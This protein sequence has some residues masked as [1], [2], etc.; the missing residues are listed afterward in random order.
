MDETDINIF[1]VWDNFPGG[2][3]DA[4]AP[5]GTATNLRWMPTAIARRWPARLGAI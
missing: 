4:A 3:D 2:I 1:D 5:S